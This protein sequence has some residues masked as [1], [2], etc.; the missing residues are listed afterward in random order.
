MSVFISFSSL[1]VIFYIFSICPCFVAHKIVF[2]CWLIW[3]WQILTVCEMYRGHIEQAVG[4]LL[5]WVT[6]S[7]IKQITYTSEIWIELKV[8]YNWLW[9]TT[10]WFTN[11]FGQISFPAPTP[12]YA[13]KYW[14]CA[15]VTLISDSLL[16]VS[17]LHSVRRLSGDFGLWGCMG[18][19]DAVFLKVQ[20]IVSQPVS[21]C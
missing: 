1:C 17:C 12:A 10:L 8:I 3:G 21:N 18:K 4:W 9:V 14:Q 5:G 20:C 11:R 16:L 6:Y 15:S 7:F 2:D 13:P 19:L